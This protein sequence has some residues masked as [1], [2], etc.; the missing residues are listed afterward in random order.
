MKAEYTEQDINNINELKTFLDEEKIEYIQDTLTI[1]FPNGWQVLEEVFYM[2]EGNLEVRYVNSWMHKQDNSKRFGEIQMGIPKD[3]FG[4]LTKEYHEKGKR[5]IWVKDYEITECKD[6][7]T[8]EGQE[9][10]GYRRKWEVLKSYICCA[11]HHI[12]HRIYAR[13]TEVCEISGAEARSFLEYACFY[14][15][16]GAS[17]TFVLKLKKDKEGLKKGTILMLFSVGMNFYGNKNCE[18]NGVKVEVIRVGTLPNYQIIG[19]SSK[20]LTYFLEKY[21]T[22]SVNRQGGYEDVPVKTVV[23]YVDADHNDSRSL[24][25][26]GYDHVGYDILGFHNYAAKDIDIDKLKVKK[27]NVFQRKPQIHKKIME[28]MSTG[29]IVA[30][31]TAG[32]DVFT[33]DRDKYLEK[34]HE[35][36]E[37]KSNMK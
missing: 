5:I 24:Y 11:T 34:L 23:F 8:P 22:I 16:R 6:I 19:G 18:T 30:I 27:G 33:L 12:H 13:D 14:G 26:L 25:T 32:T 10:K 29:H 37:K 35:N 9:I 20:L 17:H 28:L 31:G 15:F 36:K 4:S 3:Y 21:P 2:N 1:D 7:I